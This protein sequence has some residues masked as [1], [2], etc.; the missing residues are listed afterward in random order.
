MNKLNSIVKQ[1]FGVFL[2][3]LSFVACDENGID[4]ITRVEPGTDA[5]PPEI[6]LNNPTNGQVI[7][8]DE[9]I[10]DLDISFRVTDDIEIVGIRVL[11]D[12]VEV[13]SYSDFPDYRIVMETYTYTALDYGEHTVTI[14]ATDIAGNV[15]SETVSFEKTDAYLPLFDGEIFY[16][17]FDG[18]FDE[19]ISQTPASQTGSPGFAGTSV[20]EEEGTN[21]YK[22]AEGSYLSVPTSLFFGDNPPTEFSATFW[23]QLV[24]PGTRASLLV[25]SPPNSGFPDSSVSGFR[26]FREGGA[27]SQNLQVNIGYGDSNLALGP[28]FSLPANTGEWVHIAFTVSESQLNVYV[29]NEV[30]AQRDIQPISWENTEELS[31][32]S[33][34]PN[35]VHWNHNS[36]LSLMDELRF[37]DKALTAGEIQTII[38]ETD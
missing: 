37:Y 21:A 18:S 5:A 31:I 23:Y 14:E 30:V 6:T 19:L 34:A 24:T 32:M 26:L 17:S 4:D 10:T 2:L 28:Q 11:V 35:F 20:N 15:V 36:D 29:G 38:T 16:M 8:S 9:D 13:A 33:G 1:C 22:G 7:Q 3:A 12:G 25:V 27:D